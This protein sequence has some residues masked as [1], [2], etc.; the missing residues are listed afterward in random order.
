MGRGVGDGDWHIYITD[1]MYKMD[2]LYS[3][4]NSTQCSLVTWMARKSKR[5]G[6]YVYIYGWFL[7]LYTRNLI[8]PCKTTIHQIKI[9]LKN[10]KKKKHLCASLEAGITS[11]RTE[12]YMW[13]QAY[14]YY[15]LSCITPPTTT[16]K[17]VCPSSCECVLIWLESL[18][19]CH[20]VNIRL[21]W[22]R[23]GL[24]PMT[25]IFVRKE[26]FGHKH[27]HRENAMQ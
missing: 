8:Q 18:C 23:M 11:W 10:I 15:G 9:N 1:T 7:L 2:I 17:Y 14:C 25:S 5:E 3:P 4:G 13:E 27:W 6:I 12:G 21:C 22:M 26:K 19:R 24:N 20:Q 16:P